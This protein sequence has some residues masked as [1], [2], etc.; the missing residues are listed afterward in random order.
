MS[1]QFTFLQAFAGYSFAQNILLITFRRNNLSKSLRIDLR[2]EY[3]RLIE[4]ILQADTGK[5]QTQIRERLRFFQQMSRYF[6]ALMLGI[7]DRKW[8]DAIFSRAKIPKAQYI[9]R[10]KKILT[11][12]ASNWDP[13]CKFDISF[14]AQSLCKYLLIKLGL[15]SYKFCLIGNLQ[16]NFYQT[17][18]SNFNSCG[19]IIKAR[20]VRE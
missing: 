5:F 2:M 12:P 9:H 18:T 20:E 3:C 16:P 17:S 13:S 1:H 4:I 19:L 8:S 15:S 11:L 14:M 6:S 7:I 10:L